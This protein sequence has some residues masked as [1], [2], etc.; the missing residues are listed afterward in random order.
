[1]IPAPAAL[2]KNIKNAVE[3]D[4]SIENGNFDVLN[5]MNPDRRGWVVGDYIE[6]GT[7]RKSNVVQV[8]W[9]RH[10][11]GLKKVSGAD[12]K[13]DVS[14]LVILVSGR[15]KQ[16]FPDESKDIVLSEIGDYVIYTGQEHKAEALEDSCLGI[17]RWKEA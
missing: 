6:G 15:W 2:A 14:T 13:P 11:K 16:T 17:V 5:S 12:L 4:M 8:K 7:L 9:A 1:M 10:K 3:S